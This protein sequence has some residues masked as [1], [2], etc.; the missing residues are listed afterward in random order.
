MLVLIDG[1][2]VP[3]GEAKLS[4]FDATVLRGIGCFEAMRVYDSRPF[5]TERHLDRLEK[6]A[7]ALRIE[8]PSRAALT[9]WIEAVARD[10]DDG[11]VRILATPGGRVD[12]VET[13]PRVVV[14][15]QPLPE[16]PDTFRLHPIVAPWHPAGADWALTG[17]KSLSYGPNVAAQREA[18]AAGFDDALLLSRD[19]VVLEAPTSAV[20]WVKAGVLELPS[21][22]LGV[23]ESVTRAVVLEEAVKLGIDH[24]EGRFALN[25]LLEADEVMILATSKEVCSVTAI[26]ERTFGAGPVT[27]KLRVAFRAR[28]ASS[29]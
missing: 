14:L 24:R 12:D 13:P 4:I 8:L 6:S 9:S 1:E 25:D 27:E 20:A 3:P 17:V 15:S 28:V 10:R 18:V 21:L 22:D 5:E 19:D 2:V 29:S 16:V 7:R 11:V 26:G 23:L